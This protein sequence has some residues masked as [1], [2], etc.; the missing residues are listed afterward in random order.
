M[1]KCK[2]CGGNSKGEYCSFNCAGMDEK[3]NG[4]DYDSLIYKK[5]RLKR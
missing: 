1:R 2:Y 3:K 5:K 4:V